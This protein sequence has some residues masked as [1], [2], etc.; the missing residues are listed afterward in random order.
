MINSFRLQ[1]VRKTHAI[2]VAIGRSGSIRN[3]S[4]HKIHQN[5]LVFGKDRLQPNRVYQRHIKGLSTTRLGNQKSSLRPEEFEHNSFNRSSVNS[6]S[7]GF[8]KMAS[9]NMEEI[10][11]YTKMTA[12]DAAIPYEKLPEGQF[13]SL[14]DGKAT[15]EAIRSELKQKIEAVRAKHPSFSPGLAVVQVGT[16]KDSTQYVKMKRLACEQVGIVFQK[17]EF[18]ESVSEQEVEQLVHKLNADDSI[19]GIIVQ[20]PLPKHMREENI[21][22]AV[23]VEKDVDGFHVDNIG[24]LFKK[25]GKTLF[26]SCTPKGCM[27]LLKR[28]GIEIKGKRAVVVGR[29]DIVG[30]P[31]SGLLTKANATV[32]IAHS[33]TKNIAEVVGQADIVV[34]ALGVPE[35]VKGSWIKEGAVVVDVGINA[36]DDSTKKSGYRM[37]GD[38][39]YGE[40][41]KRASYITPVPGG[42]G[43]MTVA[44]LLQNTVE[45]AIRQFNERTKIRFRPTKL[46]LEVPVPSDSQIAGKVKPK[47]ITGVAHELKIQTDEL[48]Q[49]G[50]YKAKVSLDILNRI[51]GHTN[52]RYVVVAGM[53][54]TPLGEGKST[55]SIGL[56][57]GLGAHLNKTA[58]ACVRQPSQGPTFGIKG[59]AAGGGYSQ[60]IPM[61]EF[62]LHLTGDIHAVSAAN[63]LLA[64]AIDA[65]MFHEASQ[66]DNALFNRLCPVVKGKREF[67]KSM[68]SRL[69]R[70]GIN[71]TQ[72]EDLTEDEIGRFA[73]LDIDP[74]TITWNRVVDINDRFLRQVNISQ[75]LTNKTVMSRDTQF[76]ISVGSEI[77]AVLALAS[78]LSDLKARLGRMIVAFSKSG[79]P[80]YADDL[81]ITGALTVLMKDAIKPTIMQTLEGTPV[82]I[83]AGPFAN[84]AHGNSSVIAD[85]IA[86]KLAGTA[87]GE[88][89][90]APNVG[91]VITEAG[92]G[93]DIG[94]EKFMNIKCRQSGLYPDCVVVVATIRALK[95]HGGGAPVTAGAKL[96][97]D[98]TCENVELVRNGLANLVRHIENCNKF[99]I[100]VVVALNKFS[101]DSQAEIDLVV[102]TA[103][104]A[105]AYAAHLSDNWALGGAGALD[106]CNAVVSACELNKSGENQSQPDINS[107]I[108]SDSTPLK[109]KILA[110]A[111]SIYR[112]SS[113]SYSELASQ[114]LDIYEHQ[115][116]SGHLPICMAKTQYSFSADPKLKNAPSDFDLFIR[117]VRISNGA[118]F[119]Y[120]LCGDIQTMPGLPT[121]PCFYDIDIDCETGAITGLF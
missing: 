64:A 28:Y 99:K 67:S 41:R 85:R 95:M 119:V 121:R 44:M 77:M 36:V 72:P 105:G 111:K 43:P 66:S 75:T 115:L 6:N 58:I 3:I 24:N 30:T 47:L 22:N 76:D 34:A 73:R 114:K 42:V 20:L 87:P 83:H 39:E 8:L 106:L 94:F 25:K 4:T 63:N 74:S 71:K 80:V 84:I 79:A 109:E 1:N 97:D 96:H 53:T 49:Y 81:G 60:V 69:E 92:F 112:A 54:P 102:K 15:A 37:V 18:D 78:D 98:Y 107:V 65:R 9:N 32:T 11:E 104:E 113:V 5:A 62:N 51:G 55:T 45:G 91:Y 93:S 82:F 100:P 19:S 21:V 26:T 88:P 17:F 70:L 86:L 101:T 23:C 35:F 33:H 116:N 7:T 118:G 108:Y 61:D 13:A 68:F 90:T 40:A 27:E 12:K 29:S 50:K 16:R 110:L 46:N 57:Q 48:E 10:V 89:N 2:G 120:P 59:G 52:G 38:V 31:V 56:A 117:D 14:F 103:T